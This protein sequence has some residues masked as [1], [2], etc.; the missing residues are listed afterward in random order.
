MTRKQKFLALREKMRGRFRRA[1]R[2]K[3][4]WRYVDIGQGGKVR[5][6]RTPWL[7][8]MGEK[9][10]P[11]ELSAEQKNAQEP[12]MFHHP[13]Q[14][15]VTGGGRGDPPHQADLIPWPGRVS[16]TGKKEKT[17]PWSVAQKRRRKLVGHKIGR[18]N[19]A[20][21]QLW[22]CDLYFFYNGY[23][24]TDDILSRH[25]NEQDVENDP[26]LD[27]EPGTWPQSH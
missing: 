5:V 13:P 12:K 6:A 18:M 19:G 4:P 26:S 27:Y 15:V 9:Q 17:Q 1:M 8:V 20:R 22:L 21:R 24:R 23:F 11:L 7:F 2:L 14:I 3:N 25:P 16:S 10:A